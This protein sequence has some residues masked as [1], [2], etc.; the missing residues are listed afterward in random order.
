M[1]TELPAV[2]LHTENGKVKEMIYIVVCLLV[3]SQ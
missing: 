2:L 3:M 1:Q